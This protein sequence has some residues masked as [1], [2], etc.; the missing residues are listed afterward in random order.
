MRTLNWP[1]A[2]SLRGSGTVWCRSG[3]PAPAGSPR[4]GV[5]PP[6]LDQYPL[7]AELDKGGL[8]VEPAWEGDLTENTGLSQ[9]FLRGIERRALL[10]KNSQ[11]GGGSHNVIANKGRDICL[12]DVVN[13]TQRLGGPLLGQGRP[14]LHRGRHRPPLQRSNSAIPCQRLALY[15]SP[16]L[17]SGHVVWWGRLAGEAG[18]TLRVHLC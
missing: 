6:L 9:Y 11:D 16:A 2:W 1:W 14:R 15:C 4:D 3:D 13:F 10:Y 5:K 7:C 12:R 17:A 8:K 18:K